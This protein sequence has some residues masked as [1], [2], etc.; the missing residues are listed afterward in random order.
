ML[1]I[2]TG[3]LLIVGD[4]TLPRKGVI[5]IEL[6]QTG[7][8]SVQLTGH[9]VHELHEGIGIE[10]EPLS[11]ALVDAVETLITA[12]DAR[13]S[14][15]PPLP[16]GRPHRDEVVPPPGPRP[17]DAFGTG[18]DP[19]PPRSA[20]PDERAEYLRLLLK[21]RDETLVNGRSAFA[22][23]VAEADALREL[24][25]RLK[26]RLDAALSMVTVGEAALASART[27]TEKQA[28]DLETE[29]SA[30]RDRLDEEARRTLEAIGTVAGLESK[31]RRFENEVAS[32]RAEAEA[33]RRD[34]NEVQTDVVGLRKAREEL[35]AANRKAMEAQAAFNKERSNRQI[36]EA[37]ISA[38][39]GTQREAEADARRLTEEVARLKAKLIAAEAALERSATRKV[40]DPSQ[41]RVK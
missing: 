26:T 38:A 5:E 22:A 21:K 34:A 39:L 40:T 19:R 7:R 16:A 36:A 18:P 6:R 10:F 32:A 2:S 35:S 9:V 33:A 29:R 1:N 31:L 41:R 13:N 27:A 20:S 23:V 28:A 25:T 8:K 15:P 30:T 37:T 3:G 11:P 12:V 4:H 24:A 14:M 17:N